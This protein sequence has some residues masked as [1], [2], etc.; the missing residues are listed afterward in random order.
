MTVKKK[1]QKKPLKGLGGG[2]VP[3]NT[4]PKSI[5]LKNTLPKDSSLP[6]S[7]KSQKST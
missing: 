1:A 5:P 6:K 4:L 3:D 2:K 7:K